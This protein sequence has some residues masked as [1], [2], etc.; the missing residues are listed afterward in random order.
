M[1]TLKARSLASLD[2]PGAYL[3]SAIVR[4]A[5]N[6]RR[7]L[8]RRRQAISRLAGGHDEAA[9]PTYPSDITDLMRLSPKARAALFMRD[10]EGASYDEIAAAISISAPAARMTVTRARRRLRAAIEEDQ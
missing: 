1:R 7:S 4:V 6:Q 8:G 9:H 2:N 3:R 10:V 5:S